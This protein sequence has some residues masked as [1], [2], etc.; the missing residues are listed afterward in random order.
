[1]SIKKNSKK[2]TL[3][4]VILKNFG[5]LSISVVF[6]LSIFMLILQYTATSR[7]IKGVL[8]EEIKAASNRVTW[9]VQ[10]YKNIIESI[11]TIPELSM[12]SIDPPLKKAILQNRCNE[13]G[14]INSQTIRLDGF[15]EMDGIFRGDREYFHEAKKGKTVI[16]DPII[17][18]SQG[19]ISLIVASPVWRG[20]I[21]KGSIDSVVWASIKPSVLNEVVDNLRFSKNSDAYIISSKGTY[22][23]AVNDNLV[24]EQRNNINEA[25]NN[26]A[27]KKIAKI[28]SKILNGNYNLQIMRKGLSFH[29]FISAPIE[30]TPGW[31]FIVETPI[32]D[33]LQNFY[34]SLLLTLIFGA[35][36]IIVV[37]KHT[38]KI[39]N[40][41]SVPVKRLSERLHKAAAG[42]FSSEVEID[43]SLV[44][45]HTISEATRN[46]VNRMSIV[47]NRNDSYKKSS[48]LADLVDFNDYGPMNNKIKNLM[49]LSFC[50][51]DLNNKILL[52]EDLSVRSYILSEPIM[53]YEK[54]VGFYQISPDNDC[55]LSDENLLIISKVLTFVTSKIA[56]NAIRRQ[57]IY[58]SWV[59]NELYN[60]T[61]FLKSN[62]E[63][64]QLISHWVKEL[65]E[66]KIGTSQSDL[67]SSVKIFTAQAHDIISKFEENAEYARFTEFRES[68]VEDDYALT[69]L[70][71]EIKDQIVS[72][73][74]KSSLVECVAT[75]LPDF[76]FGNKDS[77]IKITS[78]IGS[79]LIKLNENPLIINYSVEKE[80]YSSILKINF[81]IKST[82]MDNEL[83]GRLKLISQ[84]NDY[85]FEKLT[86]F[87][88][89]IFSAFSLCR[90]LNAKIKIEDENNNLNL[91]LLIP[92]L[93]VKD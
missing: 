42:D 1:M 46:L 41:I 6:V 17:S 4:H 18:R 25:L 81:N 72:Q 19:K 83:I 56:E 93:A 40:S 12:K 5:F 80:T 31:C 36:T 79:E 62:E 8:T 45:M 30:G 16:S 52:G 57:S 70:I 15:S 82:G 75:D 76:L 86:V 59:E 28:E 22:V 7:M 71:N 51:K 35:I 29:Y 48:N 58:S 47:L 14:L 43:D 90:K 55:T 68:T 65:E 78:R 33:Y 84:K 3:Y 37:F 24:I 2:T 91:T 38:R 67:K 23:A 74:N 13:F 64:S 27:L 77:I 32:T 26:P 63:F 88:K 66:M 60:L 21:Y 50:I 73:V 54:T 92:Q 69:N 9:V 61:A 85:S 11:G 20:G 53:I 87:E 44:E 34:V 49:H 10:S 39:A 89:K